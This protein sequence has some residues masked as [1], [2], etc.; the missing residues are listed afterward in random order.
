M[1]VTRKLV[2]YLLGANYESIPDSTIERAKDF[3]LDEIGN[4]LG[5]S[6]LNSGK[7]IIEWGKVLGGAQEATLF[8]DGTRVPIGI[9]SGVNTQLCMGL[10]L[11]ETYKNRAHPGSGIIMTALA[12]GEKAQL[13][14]KEM[15]TAICAAYDVTG[16]IIDAT[17][18]TP[19]HRSKVWN[20]SWQGVGPLCVALRGL[21][22]SEEQGMNAFGMGLGNAPTMNVHN[23]L[24]VPGSMS[25]LGNQFHSFVGI[26]AAILA[27][28]G[29][30]GYHEILDEPYAYWTTI[31]DSNNWDVYTDKLGEVFY[32]SSA[33]A[34]KP[35]PTCRWAQPGIESLLEIIKENNIAPE[36]IDEIS[37]FAHEKITG[38]PYDNILPKNPEDAYWSVPWPFANAALG[39]NPG[40]EWYVEERF[41]DEAVYD[42]MKKIKI[43]TLPE[44]VEAFANEPEKSITVLELKTSSGEKITKKTEYCKGDPQKPLSHDEVIEKF[45]C[46][47]SSILPKEKIEHIINT[48]EK[49]DD[50]KDMNDL[51]KYCH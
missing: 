9:A 42:F 32:I 33:L 5:G 4:A 36:Y 18:P 50:L 23:I 15:L 21:G 25:K 10:E 29:Y 43:E 12:L 28:M 26:N 49:F 40:P 41:S 19:E 27:K 48:V 2:R 34:F 45:F 51:I 31:S 30:T 11:M 14:G 37:Y 8:S 1:S 3:V 46:Q 17:F 6:A 7:I 24:Y 47:T 44:A 39:Y 35:W 16:R 38:Y 13:S 22:L 20:E